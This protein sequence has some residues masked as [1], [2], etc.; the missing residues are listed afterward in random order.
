MRRLCQAAKSCGMPLEINLLG[1]MEGR[2]Y[3]DE[4]FWEQAA[5]EGCQ[6]ILGRDAHAPK[7]ILDLKTEERCMDLVRKYHL[8]LLT[9]V[10]LQSIR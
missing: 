3:P 9:T 4:R 7:H 8:D 10:P 5:V 6:V 1:M 2:N